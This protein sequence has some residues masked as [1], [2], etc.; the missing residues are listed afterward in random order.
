MSG[1]RKTLISA[2]VWALASSA[3]V[4]AEC[5]RVMP[6]DELVGHSL[7]IAR[8]RVDE[9]DES[10]FGV[11]RTIVELELLEVLLGDN[12]LDEVRVG[13]SSMMPCANDG[14]EEDE[15]VLVF[16]ARDGGL[17]QTVNLQYGRFAI[18]GDTVVH[19]RGV[20]NVAT[21]ASFADVRA[22]IR[23]LVETINTPAATP[24]TSVNKPA[25]VVDEATEETTRP[26]QQPAKRP[27]KPLRV[28]RINKP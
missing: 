26:A 18:E 27:G 21:N 28:D 11:N 3:N 19:W 9:I 13:A 17:Y 23:R 2:L 14:Y 6:A 20:D 16:L 5:L 12:T 8:A 25:P 7:L 15:E 22:E 24:V 1:M 10:E 4:S